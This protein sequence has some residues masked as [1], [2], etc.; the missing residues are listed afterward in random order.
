SGLID[1]LLD[2]SRMEAGRL[3]VH[4]NEIRLADFL[5]Q[6]VDMVRL[7]AKAADLAFRFTRPETLP[8]I[9]ATDEKRLRQI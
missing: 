2:I 9:V 5:D 3:Q 1:G 8:L 6:I 7:Q 4:R